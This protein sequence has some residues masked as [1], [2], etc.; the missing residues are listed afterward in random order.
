MRPPPTEVLIAHLAK[1]PAAADVAVLHRGVVVEGFPHVAG[2]G[3]W[4][5]P[6]PYTTDEIRRH[7]RTIKAPELDS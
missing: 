6:V 7:L 3:C 2:P 5:R 4:C 1:Y